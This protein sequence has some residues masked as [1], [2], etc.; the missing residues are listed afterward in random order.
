MKKIF[1]IVLLLLCSFIRPQP[2]LAAVAS[3]PHLV[4]NFS[5]MTLLDWTVP[6]EQWQTELRPKI[7]AQIKEM[8]AAVMSNQRSPEG[9]ILTW[10]TLMEYM[11]TPMDAPSEHSP[12]AIKMRRI[13]EIAE[14]LDFPVFVP[15]NGF[16]WWD[17]LPELYN[18]W[19]SDGTHTDPKFFARQKDPA[20]FKRRFIAGYN[21][22][23]KWNVAWQDAQTPMKLNFRNWGGGG[24]VLAPPP[25]L[26][27][28]TKAPLSYRKLQFERQRVIVQEIVKKHVQWKA[29]GKEYLFAGLTIGTE[30]SLNA[31][32]TPKDEFKSYG[33]SEK[34]AVVST[35]LETNAQ[36]IMR[37]G[38]PK[39]LIY[40]HVLGE[41]E[42]N[43][44]HYSGIAPAAFNL[45]SSPATS[46]YGFAE[47]PLAS[48][49]WKNVI[50]QNGNPNWGAVEYT[51]SPTLSGLTTTFASAHI[52]DI[53]NWDQMK[54]TSSVQTVKTF[55]KAPVKTDN[56]EVKSSVI[57][58][59]R[60]LLAKLSNPDLNP[61]ELGH[62]I[63]VR[64]TEDIC[65][66]GN[67]KYSEPETFYI[68]LPSPVDTTPQWVKWFLG[69]F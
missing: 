26:T 19:D 34:V 62:G 52:V 64:F 61:G 56:C 11:N 24:F 46:L 22:D 15:L 18:W 35:Y 57:H 23:N 4:I 63:Y 32:V 66:N 6:E 60:G 2:A 51:S 10:S 36:F 3:S 41:Q 28:N 21:P 45:Y 69:H 65:A 55:L 38:I 16:Q 39:D 20:D 14:D 68:P 29:E 50:V 5:E 25:N 58:T 49:V 47:N 7:E 17:E 40:A 44:P 9:A 54:G 48:S 43:D 42:K 8:K 27:D 12:Y 31:S 30:I 33:G 67:R 53:Y 37:S 59:Q 1:C 13:L